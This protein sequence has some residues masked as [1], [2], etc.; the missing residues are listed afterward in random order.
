MNR[1]SLQ[2]LALSMIGALALMPLLIL[3]S[4]VG[5][6]IDYAG[7]SESQAGYMVAAGTAGGALAAI[8]VALRVHRVNLRRMTM[9]CLVLLVVF[10]L[11]AAL[12]NVIPFEALLLLRLI[13]GIL[14][15]CAYAAVMATFAR[16]EHPELG[17][18][19]FVVLQF[20]I[21]GLALY[22][23]PMV[24]PSIGAKGLF[25]GLAVAA[26]LVLPLIGNIAS[27]EHA[28]ET[29]TVELDS[30]LKPAA[31]MVLAAFGLSEAA[32][33]MHYTY[34]ERIGLSTGLTSEQVGMVMGVVSLLGLPAGMAV[35][36]LGDRLGLRWPIAI[37]LCVSITGLAILL[38]PNT[39][40][41]GYWIAM[42]LLS[43]AWA[44]GIPYFQA[45]EAKLDPG[46]SVVVAGGFVTNTGSAL[47]PA[48]AAWL[49]GR[50][51][52]SSVV[53]SSI[54]LYLLVGVLVFLALGSASM[55]RTKPAKTTSAL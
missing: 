46:G 26:V 54:V 50:G 32:N 13:S 45:A 12:I 3:P 27:G 23:L 28:V 44:F 4:L 43:M 55:H 25:V 1:I 31:L 17:F 29:D 2:T 22:T 39:G 52:Y 24:L 6:V 37:S 18:A 38:V 53:F 7:L 41:L 34:S 40:H 49:V 11:L 47:G 42:T 35:V 8:T 10:D 9:I 48:F 19:W 20:A 16:S 14:A 30:L 5:A 51:G 36:F 21:S 15:A 33:L